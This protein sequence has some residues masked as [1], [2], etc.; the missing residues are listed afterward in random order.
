MLLFGQDLGFSLAEE[1]FLSISIGT[2][3]AF[4][5]LL[6]PSPPSPLSSDAQPSSSLTILQRLLL[7]VL[8]R[9]KRVAHSLESELFALDSV[10]LSVQGLG[11]AIPSA[12]A[13]LNLK[14][15]TDNSKPAGTA[16]EH[17]EAHSSPI[18]PQS[19]S[20]VSKSEGGN[21]QT[22]SESVGSAGADNKVD[23][24]SSSQGEMPPADSV[25]VPSIIERIESFGSSLYAAS[26]RIV[27]GLLPHSHESRTVIQRI[28][29]DLRDMR[30]A[31]EEAGFGFVG[32]GRERERER[33]K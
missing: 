6:V 24:K 33:D 10:S 19:D 14:E 20:P 9:A 29:S 23:E 25:H 15:I 31:L 18:A 27:Y 28:A 7:A 8:T 3:A 32:M 2:S 22:S 5:I 11:L 17:I 12:T 13:T 4:S 1:G 30:G 21:A 26:K 16:P